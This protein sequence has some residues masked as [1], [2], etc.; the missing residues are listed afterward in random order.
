MAWR[1][2]LGALHGN[3]MENLEDQIWFRNERVHR[4]GTETPSYKT[5]AAK[6]KHGIVRH[7]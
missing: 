3:I 4:K 2:K 1:N 5:I 6:R 7:E